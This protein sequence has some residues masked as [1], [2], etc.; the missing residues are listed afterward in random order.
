MKHA[1]FAALAAALAALPVQAELLNPGAD[2]ELGETGKPVPGWMLTLNRIDRKL[3]RT[4]PDTF[5]TTETVMEKGRG[6]VLLVPY[7]PGMY[8]L[9]LVC[10]EM[11][12][13]ADGEVEVAFDAKAGKPV[14]ADRPNISLGADFRCYAPLNVKPDPKWSHPSYPLLS[15]L[16]ADPTE[17]WRHFS[18][19]VKVFNIGTAYVM[20]LQIRSTDG[21]ALNAPLYID[22]FRMTFLNGKND[23]PE[24]ASIVP[25]HAEAHYFK[26]ETM[27]FRNKTIGT[28]SPRA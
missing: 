8:D 27:N 13:P 26:D 15:W 17:E 16:S 19:K 20:T 10:G 11:N 3:L 12:V 14:G 5:F 4:Q 2:M 1:K 18:H 9:S 28:A 25:D 23:Y 6:R 22:N 7:R 24:E 21:K